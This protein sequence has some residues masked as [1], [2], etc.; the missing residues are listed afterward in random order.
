[1]QGCVRPRVLGDPVHPGEQP[2]AHVRRHR[3]VQGGPGWGLKCP[4][5]RERAVHT[6]KCRTRTRAPW[7]L[8]SVSPAP[9]TTQP[10]ART[11]STKFLEALSC[12]I[13]SKSTLRIWGHEWRLGGVTREDVLLLARCSNFYPYF[14]TQRVPLTPSS[15]NA[16]YFL[17]AR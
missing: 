4:T 1:M 5:L 7:P 15:R 9:C 12:Y 17:C 10:S 14:P 11:I 2:H 13:L 6:R 8:A 16:P 3:S